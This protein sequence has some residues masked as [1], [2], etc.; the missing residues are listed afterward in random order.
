[1]NGAILHDHLMRN[2]GRYT[3]Y[4]SRSSS[5]RLFEAA[6]RYNMTDAS[7]FGKAIT[8]FFS[9]IAGL[10]KKIGE[11]LC[12]PST[13]ENS[14]PKYGF[15]HIETVPMVQYM[16]EIKNPDQDLLRMIKRL[17]MADRSI[18]ELFYLTS[19]VRIKDESEN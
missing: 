18:L 7:E 16:H 19:F 13:L 10:D 9:G 11:Y 3:I 1:M 4:N 12:F 5:E 6:A 8:V 17:S 2:N 15:R 14:F